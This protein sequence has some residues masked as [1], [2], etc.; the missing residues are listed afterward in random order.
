MKSF[1]QQRMIST[2]KFSKLDHVVIAFSHFPAIDR[3]HIVMY[4]I[5]H[6]CYMIANSTLRD[7]TFMMRE[8]KIHTTAMNIELCTEI[9]CCHGR[10]LDM[11]A[12]KP[13]SPWTLPAH[14]MFRSRFFP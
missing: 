14:D 5:A 2:E 12:R 8:Q 4:P 13:Y 7:L 10:T 1:L 9:F 3:D 6:R 11:P